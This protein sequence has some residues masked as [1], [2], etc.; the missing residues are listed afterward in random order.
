MVTGSY[1]QTCHCFFVNS[2]MK[3]LTLSCFTDGTKFRSQT[4]SYRF[5]NHLI[6]NQNTDLNL[7]IDFQNRF[8]VTSSSIHYTP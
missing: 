6:C 4:R 7:L 2:S 1:Q 5:H 8:F 3:Q